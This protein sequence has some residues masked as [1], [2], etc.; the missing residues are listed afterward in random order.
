ML[1]KSANPTSASLGSLN[2]TRQ[3][4]SGTFKTI[5]NYYLFDPGLPVTNQNLL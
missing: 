1:S 5:Q 3:D 2:C 4:Q